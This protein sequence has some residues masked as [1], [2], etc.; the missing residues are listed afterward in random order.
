MPKSY[1]CTESTKKR[2]EPTERAK[3]KRNA[4]IKAEEGFEL[5]AET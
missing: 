5:L 1:F 3:V 2:E 4:T